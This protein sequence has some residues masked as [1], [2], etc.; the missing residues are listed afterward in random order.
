[1]KI[2]VVAVSGGGP[3]SRDT[4][5]GPKH[6]LLIR[7]DT[8]TTLFSTV[9]YDESYLG[10]CSS[11]ATDCSIANHTKDNMFPPRSDGSMPPT[12]VEI[13]NTWIKAG[14]GK[15]IFIMNRRGRP[16]GS[17]LIRRWMR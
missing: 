11:S 17:T 10:F 5:S 2:A 1:V 16:G 13:A 6:L 3:G 15:G 8:V 7:L 9:A 12:Y 14:Y 4:L